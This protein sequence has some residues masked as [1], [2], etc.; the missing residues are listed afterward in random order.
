MKMLK[1]RIR[2]SGQV[3]DMV[4]AVALRMI[5]GGTAEEVTSS[6][7]ESM[8]VAPI[9]ERAVA[10]AQSSSRKPLLSRKRA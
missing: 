3:L 1:V 9:A 6:Q 7:P 10:P 5:A 8:A 2:A 4:P